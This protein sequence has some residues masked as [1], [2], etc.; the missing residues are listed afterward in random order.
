MSSRER[1]TGLERLREL[2]PLLQTAKPF[3]V[4]QASE[5]LWPQ[6][7]EGVGGGRRPPRSLATHVLRR[8]ERK[9]PLTPEE[10]VSVLLLYRAYLLCGHVWEYTHG[11]I[12]IYMYMLYPFMFS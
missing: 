11:Y 3:A 9:V 4:Q 1:G 7:T 12:C 10:H 5:P 6:A 8:M 2:Y